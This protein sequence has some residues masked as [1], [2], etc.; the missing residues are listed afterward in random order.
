MALAITSGCARH[1]CATLDSSAYMRFVAAWYASDPKVMC[2]LAASSLEDRNDG[3]FTKL[4]RAACAYRRNDLRA[5]LQE[6]GD[7]DERPVPEHPL[8]TA[9]G[10]RVRSLA[11]KRAADF[12]RSE[13]EILSGLE[14]LKGT[15][16][17]A[18]YADLL[19]NHAE[20]LRRRADYAGALEKLVVAGEITDSLDHMPGRCTVLINRGNLYYDQ[21]RYEL[22]WDM[23]RQAVDMAIGQGLDI[24]AQNALANMGAAAQM[25]DRGEQAMQ[26]YDSLY[27]SL[28]AEEHMLR[29]HLL[30]NLA[31]VQADLDDHAGAIL[32]H[33]QALALYEAAGDRNGRMHVLQLR[34]TSLWYLGQRD[35]ALHSL[36]EALQ[37]A[38]ELERHEVR[39]KILKK[40][41]GYHEARGE[42]GRAIA[43]LQGHIALVDTLNEQRFSNSMAM[44]EVKYETEKKERLIGLR[45]AELAGERIIREKRSLQRNLLL[46]LVALLLF[47][48]WLALRNMRHRQSLALKEKELSEKRVEEVLRELELR[49][50]NAMVAGQ[51]QERDRIARELHDGLGS[52]LSAIKFQFTTMGPIGDEEAIEPVAGLDQMTT[53]IDDAVVLVRKI[54]HDMVRGGT[55]EFTLDGA[56]RDLAASITVKGRLDVELSLF[57]L[58]ERLEAKVEMASYRIVQELV[59]NALKHGRP[60]E[61]AISLT[62]APQ[63]LNILVEDNGTGF[64]TSQAADGI[65][66]GNVRKRAVDLGGTVDIDSSLGR[67]TVVSIELPLAA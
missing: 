13:M 51:Q 16:H 8:L 1:A 7:I 24:I 55:G 52:L 43:A 46:V 26:L 62:R 30:Q 66:L 27:M 5:V 42:L 59:S 33:A 25:L 61:L 49:L 11:F 60:S 44:M 3:G 48:G 12:S 15:P 6:I 64:D 47:I 37:L 22:A 29:A 9:W 54:S 17:L 53:M 2:A 31:V 18:E 57:G 67:G 28:A 65:G 14:V 21:D 32:R 36:E 23:Y 40:L 56:L 50:V 38:R 10:F 35:E 4:A 63:R 39:S 45:E 58:E 41:A 34:A 20:L 19:V